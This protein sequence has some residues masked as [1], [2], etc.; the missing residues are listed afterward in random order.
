MKALIL[1]LAVVALSA[2]GEDRCWVCD[3]S[4]AKRCPGAVVEAEDGDRWCIEDGGRARECFTGSTC[5][6]PR[7]RQARPA[8]CVGDCGGNVR[9]AR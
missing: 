9:I 7:R 1:F 4:Q 8:D 2:C 6:A 3:G 5:A